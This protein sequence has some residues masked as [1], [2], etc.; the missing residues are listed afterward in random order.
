MKPWIE[1][2]DEVLERMN[3]KK[4]SK[5]ADDDKIYPHRATG[6]PPNEAAKPENWF[7]VHNN[8]EVQAK[9][10]RQY[11]DVMAGDKVKVYRSRAA[12]SKEVE[13]EYK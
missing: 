9:H 11:P 8:M 7:E 3:T 12:L 4:Q 6:Y 1:Y 13:G 10:R 2:L 5:D